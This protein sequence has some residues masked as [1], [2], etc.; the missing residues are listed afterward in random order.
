[1]SQNDPVVWSDQNILSPMPFQLISVVKNTQLL[2]NSTQQG[3]NSP[4]MELV[5]FHLEGMVKML[6]NSLISVLQLY[7][8]GAHVIGIWK[9]FCNDE[10]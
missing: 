9:Q 8:A 7:C 6:R 2:C 10:R 5:S 3:F 4:V 1:M